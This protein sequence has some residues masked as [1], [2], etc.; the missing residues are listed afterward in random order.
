M[1]HSQ[2]PRPLMRWGY[3]PGGHGTIRRAKNACELVRN[4]GPQ[5]PNSEVG[6]GPTWLETH[7]NVPAASRRTGN[8]LPLIQGDPTHTQDT[9][10]F[11]NIRRHRRGQMEREQKAKN[12]KQNSDLGSSCFV[13]Q[14]RAPPGGMSSR[15]PKLLR[16]PCPSITSGVAMRKS[17]VDDRSGNFR[18]MA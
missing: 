5:L 12:A 13:D 15:I 14:G 8:E 10:K 7:G 6:E 18:D 17:L 9:P 2:G 11:N 1:A 4:C 16:T 3:H